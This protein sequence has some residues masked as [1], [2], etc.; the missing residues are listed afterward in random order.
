MYAGGV[1]RD[2]Q[3]TAISSGNATRR[4]DGGVH[5][6]TNIT[7][8]TSY[9]SGVSPLGTH[10]R[11]ARFSDTR[12]R[13]I[14]GNPDEY[15]MSLVRASVST[16]SIPLFCAKPSKLVTDA[17][18]QAWE[19][20][21]EPGLNYT[22]TGP[23]FAVGN[24]QGTLATQRAIPGNFEW[25]F[26]T[27]PKTGMIPFYTSN[28]TPSATVG[29]NVVPK[30][31]FIDLTSVS[32]S[33]NVTAWGAGE[34]L[35]AAFS[36]AGL[37][38]VSCTTSFTSSSDTGAIT[39]LQKFNFVNSSTTMSVFLDFSLPAGR[40][41]CNNSFYPSSAP[42]KQG[43]LQ[44]CK[45]LGFQPNKVFEIPTGSVSV[46]PPR[47]YQLG[48]RST[49]SLYSYKAVRWV[50]EDQAI[51][52]IPNADDV[53]NGSTGTY[54]DCYSYEHFLTECVNPAF[55]RCI[56][57]QFDAGV[58][59]QEQCLQRQL[60]AA[61]AINCRAQLLWSSDTTY[62]VGNAVVYNGF[63]YA[64]VD[65]NKGVQ[66][67]GTPLSE[68][69]WINCGQ[70]V[71]YTLIAPGTGYKIY[72]V[73]TFTYAASTTQ[74]NSY[75]CIATGTTTGM[76]D[77]TGT[78]A[79]NGWATPVLLY[80]TIG[81][82]LTLIPNTPTVATNPPVIMFQASTQLF[83][84]NLDSY[85]FGGTALQ[86]VDDGSGQ[87]NDDAANSQALNF[88]DNKALN[89]VARD[90]YG[91][92]G[93]ATFTTPPYTVARSRGLCYDERM[94]VEVD[95]YFHQLFG[96]W[97]ALRLLYVDPR[98]NLQTSYIRYVPQALNAGLSTEP[99]LPLAYPTALGTGY[100]PF[101][102]VASTQPYFYTIP[103]DY[104][105]IGLMWNPVD[106]IVIVTTNVPVNDDQVV[107]VLVLGDSG[108]PV[109]QQTNGNTLK[110]IGEFSVVPF[111]NS[112][113]GQE[114]RNEIVFEPHSFVPIDLKETRT[115]NQFDYRV[116]LRMK[117]QLYRDMSLS[118]GGFVN[119]RFSFDRKVR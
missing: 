102:R 79:Q 1:K 37:S 76:P 90:S 55:Q 21:A 48:L 39:Y 82:L 40:A 18:P 95:D 110:V 111:G 52:R 57:D 3:G 35:T 98:D 97:P 15:T 30:Q 91:L 11:F 43:I 32:K 58:P 99:V 64:A 65:P 41:E 87:T 94:Q 36:A 17:S 74:F 19:V 118:N 61:C 96:N 8:S 72:D 26:V 73:V 69:T 22:W 105:S 28:T 24:G 63:A 106:T 2:L 31:G 75:Y 47:N 71:N 77:F 107:P 109:T 81:S 93:A 38:N 100:Q 13:P 46:S 7:V 14:V 116:L 9:D 101:E 117:N 80:N 108:V 10:G 5:Y 83:I 53:A 113:A 88:S 16:N 62:A 60:I 119:V 6:D 50:P 78:G 4:S 27:F 29:D 115:F 59:L 70:A 103:Q 84:L 33:D 49:I 112:S 42:T 45:F 67:T 68:T 85:G 104:P 92:T 54:F 86:N 23:V 20:T 44:A 114:Y 89:D 56:F 12:T 25:R 34:R 51:V 66:P